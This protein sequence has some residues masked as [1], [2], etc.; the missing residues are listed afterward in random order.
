VRGLILTA[1]VALALPACR[2]REKIRTE[3]TEENLNLLSE[4]HM[5]DPAAS[6]QLI[7]GFHPLEQNSWRWT[8]GKFAVILQPP[9]GSE[10]TGAQVSV[11]LTVPP[12]V[13]ERLKGVTLAILLNGVQLGSATWRN[14]G[15]Y[16]FSADV[17][18]A[19]L[20]TEPVTF[21]FVLDRF[22]AAGAVDSR[23]LGLIVSSVS[24]R[25]R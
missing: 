1:V 8:Q 11:Q 15:E 3:P 21:D 12:P 17:P 18:S 20:G 7:R 4:V 24:L 22:L 6:R 14:P 25:K 9:A 23:E 13:V 2:P 19:S 10:K 5:A 16:T